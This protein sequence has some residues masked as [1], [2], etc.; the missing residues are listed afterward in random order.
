MVI[1][2]LK[3]KVWLFSLRNDLKFGLNIYLSM[4]QIL[5]DLS[6]SVVVLV[7]EQGMMGITIAKVE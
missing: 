4:S 6:K 7:L 2:V 5:L 3:S 1:F